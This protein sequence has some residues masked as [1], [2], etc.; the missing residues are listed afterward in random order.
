MYCNFKRFQRIHFEVSVNV[1]QHR[2]ET[3]RVKLRKLKN[4]NKT[5]K[6]PSTIFDL[7]K[8]QQC[9]KFPGVTPSSVEMA[10]KN[11]GLLTIT[12]NFRTNSTVEQ[13]N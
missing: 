2:T 4:L 9:R 7:K 10:S 8:S 12:D 1:D 3:W 5:R 11:K 6:I 13:H